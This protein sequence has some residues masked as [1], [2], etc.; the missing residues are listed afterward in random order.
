[1]KYVPNP[2]KEQLQLFIGGKDNLVEIG[3]YSSNGQ[4]V[5]YQTV[6]LSFGMRN[7]TLNTTAFKPGVYIIRINGQTLDQSIQVIKE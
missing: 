7:Y 3:V 2:F 4:L 5:D 1:M 6:S